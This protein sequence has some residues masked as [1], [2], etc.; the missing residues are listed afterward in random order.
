[1]PSWA[2]SFRLH[3]YR[4]INQLIKRLTGRDEWGFWGTPTEFISYVFKSAYYV[5]DMEM[6][7]PS[8]CSQGDQPGSPVLDPSVTHHSR[9][10]W[11]AAL[12]QLTQPRLDLWLFYW[13]AWG[14]SMG[15][16]QKLSPLLL[17][18]QKYCISHAGKLLQASASLHIK[19]DWR[20]APNIIVQRI[21]WIMVQR[22]M[23]R[24][25]LL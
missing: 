1:M 14:A 24:S 5:L 8:L 2:E 22:P 20:R 21:E 25:G 18:W 16:S 19:L 3:A 7:T 13:W 9:K 10:R 12:C 17:T 6:V 4:S 23:H 15:S 11:E